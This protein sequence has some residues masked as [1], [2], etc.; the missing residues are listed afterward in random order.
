[1]LKKISKFIKPTVI[2]NIGN[3]LEMEKSLLDIKLQNGRI[4][5]QLLMQ[6]KNIKSLHETEF[7][8][9]SQC[10]DDGIIQYLIQNLEIENKTFVEFGV[11]DY[12]ESNTRFLLINNNWSGLVMDGSDSNVLKIKSNEQYWKHDL[13]AKSAFITAENINHLIEEEGLKGDIGLLHIDIDGNDY[14]IWKALKVV[15]PIIMIVEYNSIFG[16]ERAITIPYRSDFVRTNAHHSNLYAGSSILALCDLANEKG[17]SFIG[18]NS[19]GNNAY[20]VKNKYL[21]DFKPL[22]AKEGYVLSKFRES[23]DEHGKLNYLRA[24]DRLKSIKGL[25]VYNTRSNKIEKL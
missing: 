15:D 22:S 1:M 2:N 8:V 25:P 24:K 6:K 18:S 5:S 16:Y 10:G 20:F 12:L 13:I 3:N 9:F 23:R 21:K 19:T 4:W 11:E 17:Y 14:W 7:K